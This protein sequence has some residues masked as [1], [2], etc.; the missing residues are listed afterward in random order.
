[1]GRFFDSEA[2]YLVLVVLGAMTLF[3][4]SK[5]L[6]SRKNIAQTELERARVEKG[7]V[8][9]ERDLNSN[10]VPERFYEIEG[11]KAFLSVDGRGVEDNLRP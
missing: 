4:V 2:A 8:L 7:Y 9:Q 5:Y 3:G 6:D 10:G 11:K 1:M